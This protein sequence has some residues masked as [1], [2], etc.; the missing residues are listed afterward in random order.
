MANPRSP[1]MAPNPPRIL[2]TQDE[3][4][5]ALMIEEMVRE[6]GYRV[7]GVAHTMAMARQ[8]F[9]RCNF[10]AGAFRPPYRWTIPPGNCGTFCWT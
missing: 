8:E 2:A 6:A 1:P 9:A 5:I 3:L 10:D 4:L 7:S